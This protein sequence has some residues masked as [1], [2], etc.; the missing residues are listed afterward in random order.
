VVHDLK[1]LV[2]QLSLLLKNSERHRLN[3]QFQ[4]D[5][6][7]TVEHVTERMNK[8]LVQLSSGSR[9][10]E[11][12]RPIDLGRLAKRVVDAKTSQRGDIRIETAGD[13]MALG[14]EQRCERV[15]GHLIQNAIDATHDGG[16]IGIRVFAEGRN[17]LVEITDTG[18][19][20]SE[21]FL[22]EKLFR[23]FQT[24]KG[25]GMGIGAYETAQYV[26]E[27][28]GRIEADSRPG[29]GTKVKIVFPLHGENPPLEQRNREVA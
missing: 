10:T 27:I 20:M 17:A 21:E 28:G 5:M 26:K 4:D 12:L 25:S 8:L 19:G 3:P 9:G 6:L 29:A 14:Y 7:S 16:S 11:D 23:P 15:F 1:N 22:R 13:V 2:A 24:T 18:C